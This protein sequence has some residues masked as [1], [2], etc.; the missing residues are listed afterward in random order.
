MQPGIHKNTLARD[1]APYSV[2]APPH[3]VLSAGNLTSL[4]MSQDSWLWHSVTLTLL[5]GSLECPKLSF[6]TTQALEKVHPQRGWEAAFPRRN[7]RTFISQ[8]WGYKHR[9]S[10]VSYR[11]DLGVDQDNDLLLE[12][13]VGI[14]L[15]VQWLTPRFQRRG[16]GLEQAGALR[17]VVLLS[18]KQKHKKMSSDTTSIR[19]SD[20]RKGRNLK[21]TIQPNFHHPSIFYFNLCMRVYRCLK[22]SNVCNDYLWIIPTFVDL[23]LVF[24]HFT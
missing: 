20:L 1:P 15:V 19:T 18:Q 7:H 13:L 10:P 14:S 5:R 16:H 24:F 4:M 9:Q 3:H 22:W 2:P 17:Y 23:F 8:G 11:G 6:E 21:L 12:I